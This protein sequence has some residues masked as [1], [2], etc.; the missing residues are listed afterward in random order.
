[1]D[2]V[3]FRYI[4]LREYGLLK[5]MDLSFLPNCGLNSPNCIWK[6]HYYSL[7]L[8]N[9]IFTRQKVIFLKI[10]LSFIINTEAH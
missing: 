2:N 4:L 5:G 8:F 7:K 3:H 6:N 9:V 10:L 1:M